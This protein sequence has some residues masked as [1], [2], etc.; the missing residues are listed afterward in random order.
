M[1]ARHRK[2]QTRALA[3]GNQAVLCQECG[4][5]AGMV[6]G[7]AI[8]P[9]RPDLFAKMFW[10]C[11]CGAYVGCHPGTIIALGTPCGPETRA[12]RNA[13][14]AAL[15]PLWRRKIQRDGVPRHEARGAAY[16][17]LA[18]QL[19][20]RPEDCHI[21]MM[22]QATAR[23]VVEVCAPYALLRSLPEGGADA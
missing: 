17:W 7:R 19:S 9:H 20:M 10:R 12:A 6:D 14:H 1:A 16:A 23:R 15:D 21:A 5:A 11:D 2:A 18:D 22:D 13:A 4:Q 8:Y 3:R